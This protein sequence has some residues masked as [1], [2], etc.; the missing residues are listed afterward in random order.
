MNPLVVQPMAPSS[1]LYNVKPQKRTA[2]TLQLR[3][4][5]EEGGGGRED[6]DAAWERFKAGNVNGKRGAG[7]KQGGDEAPS[8]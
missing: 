5:R 3:A 2:S 6:W 1:P 7:I 8:R 4:K